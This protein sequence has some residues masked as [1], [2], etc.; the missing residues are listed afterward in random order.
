V[1]DEI[2]TIA[3]SSQFVGRNTHAIMLPHFPLPHFQRICG[4]KGQVCSF[5]YELAAGRL[6]MREWKNREQI[7]GVENA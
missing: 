2:N 3:L 1:S 5:A 4:L 6:K 7:A